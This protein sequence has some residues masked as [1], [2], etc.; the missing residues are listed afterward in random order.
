MQLAICGLI[1]SFV[2]TVSAQT[3]TLTGSNPDTTAPATST[4]ADY[5]TSGITYADDSSTL[6]ITTTSDYATVT[7]ISNGTSSATNNSTSTSSPTQTLLVG[8][9]R[10]T[11][12]L[13]G[14]ATGNST[15]T[16][17][18][19]SAQPTNTVPCNGYP[20]FCQ[21]KFSNITHVAAHNSPFVRQD[22]LA[23][24]QMLNVETQ[25]NDGIRMRMVPCSRRSARPFTYPFQYNSKPT[26]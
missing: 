12:S 1:A 14:T 9:S 19:T 17:T 25:L 10:T 18:L 13:N 23:A 20:E 5:A 26:S 6:S 7:G 3:D 22:S 21:R 4:G 11:T 24:N 8:S 15:A 16:S 2:L